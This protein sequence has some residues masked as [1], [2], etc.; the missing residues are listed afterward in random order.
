MVEYIYMYWHNKFL[1]KQKQ[2]SL[3]KILKVLNFV[4]FVSV[5]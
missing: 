3:N 4:L 1:P 5:K 2:F